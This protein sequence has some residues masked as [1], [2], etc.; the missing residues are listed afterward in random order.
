MYQLLRSLFKTINDSVIQRWY[1]YEWTSQ[2]FKETISTALQTDERSGQSQQRSLYASYSHTS[3]AKDTERTGKLKWYISVMNTLFDLSYNF[4]FSRIHNIELLCDES[5]SREGF[6]LRLYPR[7]LEYKKVVFG[8]V[9]AI[10][11]FNF[12]MLQNCFAA[13]W[14]LT[15]A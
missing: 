15:Q 10:I 13:Q 11:D 14:Q 6:F 12:I 5:N 7:F 3:H 9:F 8:M 1:I 4:T 2:V